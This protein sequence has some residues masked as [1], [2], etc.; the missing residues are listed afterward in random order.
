MKRWSFFAYTL[1]CAVL[2]VPLIVFLNSAIF[3]FVFP[4]VIFAQAVIAL[5][6]FAM[7]PLLL[8]RN[9]Q[10]KQLNP[11]IILLAVYAVVLL[12][13]S[14]MAV[15]PARAFWSNFERMTG[16]IFIFHTMVLGALA[17]FYFKIYSEQVEGFLLFGGVVSGIT[18][19]VGFY[20][21]ID[22]SFLLST[23]VRVGGTFGNPIYYGGYAAL[24]LVI[25]LYLFYRSHQMWK[26]VLC[27]SI[28]FVNSL[29]VILSG[30]R[31]SFVALLL[32]GV[33]FLFIQVLRWWRAGNKKYALGL[34]AL[35]LGLALFSV[36]LIR[37]TNIIPGTDFLRRFTDISL[38]TGTASTRFIA[39]EI[40]YK[41]WREHPILGWGPEN[42]YYV[43]NKYFDARSPLFG[44]YETWFDHAHNAPL[45]VLVTQ[46]LLGEIL[47]LG[48]YAVLLWLCFST[49]RRQ[50]ERPSEVFLSYVLSAFFVVH[51]VQNIF[52]FDHPAS[53]VLFYVVAGLV[54]ARWD[55]AQGRADT[56][57]LKKEL[58][59]LKQYA[60]QGVCLLVLLWV[61]VP[62]V[63]QN[64]IDLQA[65]IIARSD[66]AAARVLFDRA[67][68]V[69][70]PHH[71][72]VLLDTGRTV[73]NA[74]GNP[75]TPKQVEM[76]QYGL[77]ALDELVELDSSHLIAVLLNAQLSTN[78]IA[79]GDNGRIDRAE[80]LFK[81]AAELSPNRQQ[82]FYAWGKL[83][84][85]ENDLAGGEKILQHAID[86][87]PRLG[88][89]HWYM[90][91]LLADT[92]A[93]RSFVEME[94]ARTNG[95]D[96][97]AAP[98]RFIAAQTYERTDHPQEAA[99][100][101]LLSLKENG[102]GVPWSESIVK[103]VDGLAKKI[104][105]TEL[106]DLLRKNFPNVFEPTA[107]K[108]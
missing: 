58:R 99:E 89:S 1:L 47:Y 37:Y 21:R 81:R 39:W 40:A 30:T 4:K 24:F 45:D 33:M 102:A 57:N 34:P 11:F 66:L 54:A 41:G 18:S 17:Y 10:N 50:K 68:T 85:I 94:L 9:K 65:Q 51:F 61:A 103:A 8:A 15:S 13:S 104:K 60:L 53:Y 5:L 63:R 3:P 84:L 56:L 79:I 105:H 87:E 74:I 48:Q 2:L 16:A 100:L 32:V 97:T 14:I 92:D 6:G 69:N 19:L 59:P 77:R 90:A 20:Q 93:K 71:N 31:G 70:G 76:Y 73:F 64:Y 72:D 27:G 44:Q 22:P 91:V 42:F 29:A 43:F 38:S 67:R 62:S 49:A 82:V 96:V 83:K 7:V 26:K 107:N 80:Q 46:G 88:Q 28:I 106:Q 95:F 98:N 12:F 86:V 101:Y 55:K 25:S 52:V 75:Q 108:K 23:G 36:L 78:L 35:C